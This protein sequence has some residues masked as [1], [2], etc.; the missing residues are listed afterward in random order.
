MR[1]REERKTKVVRQGDREK[2]EEHANGLCKEEEGGGVEHDEED[3]D[4]RRLDH[5]PAPTPGPP[6]FIRENLGIS[7][8]IPGG[9]KVEVRMWV[10]GVGLTSPRA[11][12]PAI[13]PATAHLSHYS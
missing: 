13:V 8:K 11:S 7:S 5:A 1:R 3:V 12:Y 6:A 2:K 10:N 9:E 4:V